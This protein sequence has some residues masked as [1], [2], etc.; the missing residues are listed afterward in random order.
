MKPWIYCAFKEEVIWP[1][2][3][4]KKTRVLFNCQHGYVL[5]KHLEF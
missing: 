2:K 3:D 5:N 4:T 1:W